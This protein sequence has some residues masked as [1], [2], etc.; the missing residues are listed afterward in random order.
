MA[1]K[2]LFLIV[3]KVVNTIPIPLAVLVLKEDWFARQSEVSRYPARS[4][5]PR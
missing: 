3:G 4:T 5:S 2:R 1:R